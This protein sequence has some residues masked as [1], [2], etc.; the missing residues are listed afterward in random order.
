MKTR[1]IIMIDEEKCTGCGDC[2]VGCHEGALQIVDGVAKLVNEQFC[3]GFGDC[4]GECPTG[5]LQIEERAAEGFDL[6]ATKEHVKEL[7]GSEAAERMMKAQEEHASDEENHSHSGGCPGSQMKV[8]NKDN[9]QHEHGHGGGC[10]GSKMMNLD[11]DKTE[12][13]TDEVTTVDSQLEQWPVQIDLLAPQAPYFA[14]A[15]L[16][17]TAD[18]VPVAYGDYQQLLKGKAVAMGCPKLDDAEGYV[19]KLSAIIEQNDLN[20]ISIVRMEVPCCGGMTKIVEQALKN[21]GSDLN[22]EVKTV[23]INGELK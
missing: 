3:D 10:P 1:E 22:V 23:G 15:D 13:T 12:A 9:D 11:Q 7:R 6:D 19:N 21:A 18:C 5:A 8:M 20:S 17:I 2:I 4:V 16:L 14:E